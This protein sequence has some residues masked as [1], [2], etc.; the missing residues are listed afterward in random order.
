MMNLASIVAE[1]D[2]KSVEAITG[3]YEQH[4][5][6]PGFGSHL[7]A[8]LGNPDSDRGMTW[9]IK[10]HLEEEWSG[11]DNGPSPEEVS[12]MLKVLPRCAHWEAQLHLLQCLD[13]V[14]I[15]GKSARPLA[16]FLRT[17]ITEETKFVRAWAYHGWYLL[18]Q[19]HPAY[20][21]EATGLLEAA[22]NSETA[23]SV[24]VKIRKALQKLT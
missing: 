5:D 11:G 10:H 12:T 13:H 24:K 21:D 17:A 19:Q 20:L 9:L 3:I 23:A 2:G 7:I 14:D 22:Q 16:V 15:P 1:W 18:A 4:K 6:M 8:C